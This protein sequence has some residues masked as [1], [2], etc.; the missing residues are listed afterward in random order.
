MIA[1][2]YP[3]GVALLGFGT[4]GRAVAARLVAGVHPGVRL[5]RICTRRVDAVRA[6]STWIPPDVSWT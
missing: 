5:R 2:P 3:L 1:A 4:V 6:A